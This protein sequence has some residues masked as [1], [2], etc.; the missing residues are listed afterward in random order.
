MHGVVS[1]LTGSRTVGSG[2][3]L[4]VNLAPS[5]RLQHD[6]F[7][8]GPPRRALRLTAGWV[9]AVAQTEYLECARHGS[10][11]V[12]TRQGVHACT[13]HSHPS[14]RVTHDAMHL[15]TLT[16]SRLLCAD[17]QK[18]TRAG[19]TLHI[20]D[21]KISS[22]ALLQPLQFFTAQTR[23]P[24]TLSIRSALQ[25]APGVRPERVRTEQVRIGL[26]VCLSTAQLSAL[27][28][29]STSSMC[30]FRSRLHRNGPRSAC[31][32]GSGANR[33]PNLRRYGETAKRGRTLYC[34]GV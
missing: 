21:P 31:M 29:L 28:C 10:D 23:T 6:V 8:V 22:P 32:S 13:V 26:L 2:I 3:G 19:E 33:I 1:T 25:M 7:I 4:M 12:Y 30:P 15:C 27:Q 17:S 11:K 24:R 16:R 5:T 18:P 34:D 14:H 20:P 9:G